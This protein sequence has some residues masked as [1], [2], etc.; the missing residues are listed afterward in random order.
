MLVSERTARLV[1]GQPTYRHPFNSP[2]RNLPVVDS[3]PPNAEDHEAP[4]VALV[5]VASGI[6]STN[7]RT[8]TLPAQG[9]DAMQDPID[10]GSESFLDGK[11]IRDRLPII[12][13]R[14]APGQV[15]PPLK[16]LLLP[17]GELAQIHNGEPG[18]QYLAWIDLPA[19]GIRGN[20]VH[21]RKKESIYLIAGE[22][23]VYLEDLATGARADFLMEAG[24][25]VFI[26]PGIAHALQP[27][28]AG[29]ALE[30]APDPLDPTDSSPHRVV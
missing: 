9:E 29:H 30:F 3:L 15:L 24:D 2:D 25:R 13:G 20:H 5:L 11:V 28:K 18:L 23:R 12:H 4:G 10:T 21:Q 26:P 19:G 1:L 14:P 16:R 17:Q 6:W 27:V 22:L 7:E 8:V